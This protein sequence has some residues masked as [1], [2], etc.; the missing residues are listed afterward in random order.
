[1][2]ESGKEKRFIKPSFSCIAIHL[3]S[4]NTNEIND[5]HCY[6]GIRMNQ[7]SSLVWIDLEMTGLNPQVD[8]ILE[9][10]TIITDSNLNI[11]AEGPSLV[12][13]AD[14]RTLDTM[15]AEVKALHKKS[16][17]LEKAQESTISVE[18]AEAQTVTFLK[19]YVTQGISPLCGNSIWC[20]RAFLARFMPKI[21]ALLHYRIIDVSTVKELVTRWYPD[22]PHADFEKKEA[23]RALDD[24]KESVE[25]L[26]QYRRYFFKQL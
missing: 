26:K 2:L 16:G 3:V 19:E 4:D 13:Q 17:L 18:Q 8:Q 22:N 5:M 21:L 14:Q 6:K 9:I 11:I 12:L 7:E 10:A 23:H 25:E 20:D 15:S 24:I 1:M